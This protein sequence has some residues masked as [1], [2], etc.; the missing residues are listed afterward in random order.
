MLI[1][2]GLAAAAGI[3][4]IT[5]QLT[6]VGAV[7][8]YCL[9]IHACGITSAGLVWARAGW[10]ERRC[11]ALVGLGLLV[12]I[13]GQVVPAPHP[14]ES[15]AGVVATAPSRPMP[16]SPTS[17]PQLQLQPEP[18]RHMRF[19]AGGRFFDLDPAKFPVLGSPRARHFVIVMSDYTCEHCRVTHRML[20]RSFASFGDDVG[21]IVLPMLLDPAS[22]PYLPPGVAHPLPQDTALTRLAL[23]V[24]CAKPEA[25][26]EMNRW[27]F[28]EDR[29]RNEDE[30]RAYAT[31]LI[32]AD[33]LRAAE[34][35]PRIRQIILTGCELFARTGNGAIPKMLIGSMMI[36][37]PVSDAQELRTVM[38]REWGGGLTS[39]AGGTRTRE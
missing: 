19:V 34:A 38:Q 39:S 37:G 15:K 6:V 16:A 14:Y 30:A 1:A 11:L 23:A 10:R 35:D 9:A 29:V 7:C 8:K 21:V 33:A 13:T 4:F 36:T 2:T 25:F 26:G 20:E 24:L 18:D 5:I 28:A 32:G 3:W 27:L 12:L 31:K 22:N 17:Q